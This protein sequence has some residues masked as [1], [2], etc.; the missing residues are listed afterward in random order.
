[1]NFLKHITVFALALLF[2]GNFQAKADKDDK[3]PVDPNVKKGKLDNGLTYYIRHN[4]VPEN[5][6]ELYLFVNAGAVQETPDQNGLAHFCEHMAFNGTKHFP[7]KQVLDYMESIGVKFG[8]NVNAF[9]NR[10]QTVYSLAEVPTDKETIIDSSLLVLLDWANYVSYEKEEID[11]ERGVIHEEWR[12]RRTP[13]FRMSRE[14][15]KVLFK[16]SKYAEHDVIGKLDVIDNCSYETLRS[17]YNDWYRPDLQAIAVVGDIDE[18]LIEKKIK[19]KFSQIELPE[20]PREHTIE[21]IPDN[22]EP[23]VGIATD[24]EAS[25]SM[26]RILYK[27][28]PVEDKNMDYYRETIKQDLY[29]QMFRDRLEEY[30]Q[31]ENPP[32]IYGTAYYGSIAQSK[33]AYM[34]LAIPKNDQIEKA[35]ETI[36]KENIRL[37]RH[38]FTQ[39]EL[40]RNKTELINNLKQEYDNRD[41]TKSKQYIWKYLSNFSSDEPIPGIEFKYEYAKKMLPEVTLE[42]MNKLPK[43]WIT[44]KNMVVT[45]NAVQTEENA[46]P[47]E[48]Q[49]LNT[50]NKIKGSEIEA[51]KEELVDKELISKAP[52]VGKIIDETK[53]EDLGTT[54]WTL[55]NG[56]KVIIKPTDFKDNEILMSAYSKGGRS[57]TTLEETPTARM[58]PNIISQ[59]GVGDFSHTELKKK[60]A[61]KNVSLSPY[62]N[63][64]SEGFE[65]NC[66]PDDLETLLKLNY[67]Y[68]TNP[69]EDQVAFNAFLSRVKA[70]I[71]NKDKD[72]NNVFRDS[73]QY[74]M[75]GHNPRQKPVNTEYLD[76]VDFETMMNIYKDRFKDASDFTYFF[77]GN[78]DPE[79]SKPLI[80]KYIG[81]IKSIEREENWKNQSL[82]PPE[83]NYKQEFT[84]EMKVPKASTF[85]LYSGDF[86]YTHEDRVRM[87]AIEHILELRYTE[88][89]RE[90]Q[91]GSYGVYT[92]Q[93]TNQFPEKSF[94]LL[95]M[96]DSDPE[97]QDEL[98]NIV[99]EEV[100]K[101]YNEGPKEE[102]LN[103]AK[104]YFLKKRE[105]DLK[106]NDFWLNSLK[107][108]YIHNE[109]VIASENYEEI[110]KSLTVEEIKAAAGKYL[111]NANR[112][113]LKMSSKN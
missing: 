85:V 18:E 43:Q 57:L 90:E 23:L 51:Y 102:D 69:R 81:G 84:K 2:I 6:A 80:E 14:N 36:V 24:K 78:I 104:K 8:H 26:M 66:E 61:G 105:Q 16:G 31:K 41:K 87:A 7:D 109:N 35:L 73:I 113:D 4:E 12:T 1:M 59:S 33:D 89:I 11:K 108:N 22:E 9:T 27:H 100:E 38:G 39:S 54:E 106:E 65:G 19:E 79:K 45:I 94:K 68:M 112:V 86:D 46:I 48:A 20:N 92:S 95:M 15:D 44:D 28:D 83:G 75:V 64:L 77:V 42:E 98:A 52:V 111:K 96:F 72:P 76:Q 21:Q 55:D 62:L 10:E 5:R 50:I 13:S 29:T 99:Y 97:R 107:H 110:V 82:M 93:M 71:A 103:K 60:L 47:E 49:V 53:N 58:L 40:E 34:S 67:L 101:L 17:F 74:I 3:V 56:A 37:K 63:E 25:R 88:T 70:S 32:F 91:G 30:T